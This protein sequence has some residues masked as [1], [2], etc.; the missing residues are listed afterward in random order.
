M[1]IGRPAL[2]EYATF[3]ADY[4]ARVPE[5][6]LLAVLERQVDEV[7]S[8]CAGVSDEAAAAPYA[9]GKWSVRQVLGHL[10]DAERVFGFRAF[11]FS[12]GDAAPLPGFDENEYVARAPFE[13][14][15]VAAL[16]RELELVRHGHLEMFCHFDGHAWSRI[17]TANAS[18]ISVRA[19]AFIMA[20]HVRHH[21]AVLESRYGLRAA[22]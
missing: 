3:Y 12:R 9:P 16:I 1:L 17:G 10:I 5:D 15:A 21:L 20:G 11:W 22:G 7:R 19:L 6:D 2:S 4:V 18:A 13:H 8:L 14:C